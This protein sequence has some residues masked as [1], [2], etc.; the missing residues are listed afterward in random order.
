MR[1]LMILSMI[2]LLG[3]PGCKGGSDG[4]GEATEAAGEVGEATPAAERPMPEGP[5]VLLITLDTTRA[6]RLG[7]YGN[8]QQAT[9]NL[10]RIA[11]QGALF[12]RAF[13]HTPLTIPSHATILTGQYPDRHGIRDNGDHFLGDAAVTLAERFFDSGYDTA[14]SVSA[15]VTNR[16]WGFGQGFGEYFDHIPANYEVKGNIWQS[17][18][19]AEAAVAD[20]DGWLA[21]DREWP[22]FAWQHL[23]D[24]P[25]PQPPPPPHLL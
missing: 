9:P 7:C 17:E 25:P 8:P 1:H 22:F 24:P 15:Y 19:R 13:C 11:A 14:A 10:D 12:R 20:L 16:K 5:S 2:A 18:R 4:G 23:F 6:D 3:L 21:R